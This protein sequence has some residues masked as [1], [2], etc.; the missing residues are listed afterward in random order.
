VLDRPL[1]VTTTTSILSA[2]VEG[3]GISSCVGKPS[4]PSC[5]GRNSPSFDGLEG[6]RRCPSSGSRIG[7]LS[8]DGREDISETGEIDLR[9]DPP[10]L[11]SEEAIFIGQYQQ[12]VLFVGGN[13]YIHGGQECE[14]EPMSEDRTLYATGS[15]RKTNAVEPATGCCATD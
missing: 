9:M 13:G 3:R 15:E 11:S 10:D 5:D 1:P 2:S 14:E 12:L 4:S 7:P 6:D 8:S